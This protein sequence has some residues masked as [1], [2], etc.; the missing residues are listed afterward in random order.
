MPQVKSQGKIFGQVKPQVKSQGKILVK[1]SCD[2]VKS[3]NFFGQVIKSSGLPTPNPLAGWRPT[4]GR[5]V[6]LF[7]GRMEPYSWVQW[8]LFLWGMEHQLWAG[9]SLNLGWDGA[10]PSLWA[11][12][13]KIYPVHHIKLFTVQLCLSVFLA[14][15]IFMTDCRAFL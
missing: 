9:W 6:V 10:F 15:C 8:G 4:L 3:F 7:L 14:V 12:T 2:Q 13:D 1:S 11:T 5:D